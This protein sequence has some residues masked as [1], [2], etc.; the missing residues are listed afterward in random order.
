MKSSGKEIKGDFQ[1]KNDELKVKTYRICADSAPRI[2]PNCDY[3]GMVLMD[4]GTYP[5][6]QLNDWSI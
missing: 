1:F 2:D 3:V 5:T 6:K 4:I